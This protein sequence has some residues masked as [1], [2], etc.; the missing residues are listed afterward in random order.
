MRF[1]NNP[2]ELTIVDVGA[3]IGIFSMATR[4]IISRSKIFAYEPSQKMYSM[5]LKNTQALNIKCYQ[6]A[7]GLHEGLIKI[8]NDELDPVQGRAVEVT[9]AALE[10]TPMI[11]LKDVVS[12]AGN[13]IDL[14]K[15]DCEGAEW[16][17]L[18]DTFNLTK[19][20]HLVMEYHRADGKEDPHNQI[21]DLVRNAGFLILKQDRAHRDFGLLWARRP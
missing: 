2:K 1:K 7:V 19:V 6:E 3:N 5:L 10:S 8:V 21:V 20:D 11:A 15:L 9:A 18:Q 12:R 13:K 17:I 14:L 16:M 4:S